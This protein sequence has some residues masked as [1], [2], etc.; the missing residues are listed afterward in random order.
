MRGCINSGITM[1]CTRES[2]RCCLSLPELVLI[3]S[4]LRDHKDVLTRC[5]RGSYIVVFT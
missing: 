4:F 1:M 5:V 3:P 2:C